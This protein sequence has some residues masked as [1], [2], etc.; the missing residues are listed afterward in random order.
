M[1]LGPGEQCCCYAVRWRRAAATCEVGV[2]HLGR[3]QQ[4]PKLR[5]SLEGWGQVAQ[6]EGLPESKAGSRVGLQADASSEPAP[7]GCMSGARWERRPEAGVQSVPTLITSASGFSLG[8]NCW[9]ETTM[10]LKG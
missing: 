6:H 1:W 10:L 8:K 9:E 2:Q 5:P 7:G 4:G 3:R